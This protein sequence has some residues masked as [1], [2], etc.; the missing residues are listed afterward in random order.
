MQF[1][2]SQIA[3]QTMALHEPIVAYLR[4]ECEKS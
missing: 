4:D 1:I 2:S 3:L